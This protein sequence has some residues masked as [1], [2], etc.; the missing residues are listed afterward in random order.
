[1]F[2]ERWYQENGIKAP[3]D[4]YSSGNDGNC[5]IAMPTGTGKSFTIA[6]TQRRF[7]AMFRGQRYLNLTT[8]KELVSNNAQTMRDIWPNAPVGIFSAGLNQKDTAHDIIYGSVQS[9]VNCVEMFGHRDLVFVDE[10]HLV[11]PNNDTRYQLVMDKLR[12]INPAIK[13]IGYSATPYRMGQGMITDSGLFTDIAYDCTGREDFNRLIEE[14]YLSR[15]V[16]RPTDVKLDASGIHISNGDYVQSEIER[17][18]DDQHILEPALRETVAWFIHEKRRS[19]LVFVN[20]NKHVDEAVE[21]LNRMGMPTV[22]VHSKMNRRDRD[23]NIAAWLSNEIPMAVNQRILSVGIDNP[24][25]DLIADIALTCSTGNHVQKWGRGTRVFD[26]YKMAPQKQARYAALAGH[27]KTSCRGLDFVGNVPRL[28]PINDPVIPRRKGDKG[29]IAPI[30]IC[31]TIKL[32]PPA[33]GCGAYNHAS[34]RFCD[35]CGEA[36]AIRPKVLGEAGTDD[37]ICGSV[38]ESDAPQIETFNVDNVFYSRQE[39]KGNKVMLKATYQCGL[40][41]F[42]ELKGFEHGG[43]AGKV[44][45]DWWRQRSMSEPPVTVDGALAMN[46]AISKPK[47]IDVWVNKGKYAE[48]M[49]YAW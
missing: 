10:A 18:V 17:A 15:V 41:S 31:E 32:V 48:I 6:E 36:F 28:G 46:A 8:V 23:K 44:A 11:S 43:F 4:Y 24:F 35:E 25:L 19:G 26:W 42:T 9:V 7:M 5:V 2:E 3:L 45:R 20:S 47:T 22:G 1:M 39:V 27:V 29:G 40:R 38:P 33:M 16:A 12:S 13:V 37:I 49:G 30:K 34:A 21:I 14:G